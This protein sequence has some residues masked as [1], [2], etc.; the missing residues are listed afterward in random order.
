M[1]CSPTEEL[2]KWSL[3]AGGLVLGLKLV[4]QGLRRIQPKP[5]L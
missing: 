5:N 1:G 3:G 2:D 4:E